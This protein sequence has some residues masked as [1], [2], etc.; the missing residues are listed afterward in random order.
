MWFFVDS[1]VTPGT[2]GLVPINQRK[3]S[4]LS[5][6]TP[7]GLARAL[8]SASCRTN[9]SLARGEARPHGVFAVLR[10]TGVLSMHRQAIF[11]MAFVA[12]MLMAQAPVALAQDNRLQ[13]IE[14]RLSA[15]ERRTTARDGSD[16]SDVSKVIAA[17]AIALGIALFCGRWAQQ[18]GRD[19]WLWFSGAL[20]FN[21]FA[22]IYLGLA[23]GD[24]KAA[25]RRAEKRAAKEAQEL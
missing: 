3:S 19:F 25:K 13:K 10:E 9:A 20:I 2:L 4:Q 11:G 16:S 1:A 24:E 5:A 18:N 15:L 14:D 21:I 23:I 17:A 22:L 6:R 7:S 8:R 12:M